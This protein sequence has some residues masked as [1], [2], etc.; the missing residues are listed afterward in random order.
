M[1]SIDA[2]I[3]PARAACRICLDGKNPLFSHALFTP[4]F[5]T[6]CFY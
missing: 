4:I 5:A 1:S 2:G 6:D 3:A